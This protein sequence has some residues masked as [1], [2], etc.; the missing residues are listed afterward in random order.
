MIS[1]FNDVMIIIIISIFFICIKIKQQY[2]L[3]NEYQI[4]DVLDQSNTVPKSDAGL[5]N[6]YIHKGQYFGFQSADHRQQKHHINQL[7]W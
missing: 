3:L 4:L 1:S 7:H 2:I 5:E 6:Q